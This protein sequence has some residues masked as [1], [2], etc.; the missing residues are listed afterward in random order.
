MSSGPEI[1]SPAPC[2]N[3]GIATDSKSK[4]EP[5]RAPAI[6][7]E[8]DAAGVSLARGFHMPLALTRPLVA[9]TSLRRRFA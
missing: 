5:N 6:N 3:A 9:L 4:S 2:A 7:C 8:A 1:S